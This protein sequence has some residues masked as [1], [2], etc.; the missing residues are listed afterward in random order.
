MSY[1]LS[2][3]VNVWHKMY[4]VRKIACIQKWDTA[5]IL[6]CVQL[7][8]HTH[9]HTHTHCVCVCVCVYIV[10]FLLPQQQKPI[11]TETDYHNSF[12]QFN[13]A[14][15]NFYTICNTNFCTVFLFVNYCCDLFLSQFL[16]ILRE[17]LSSCSLC[18][19]IWHDKCC[20]YMIKIKVM[21][22]IFKYS[23]FFYETEN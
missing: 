15:P 11:I 13:I 6:N 5:D 2:G 17:L 21:V 1:R 14:R 19:R 20:T 7:Q 10:T 22:N 16:A 23:T 12:A 8:W 18:Q 3:N 4:C 9:T